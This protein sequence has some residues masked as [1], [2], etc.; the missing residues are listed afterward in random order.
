MNGERPSRVNIDPKLLCPPGNLEGKTGHHF[1]I[2]PPNGE[3]SNGAC[4]KCGDVRQYRNYASP[5]VWDE[6]RRE[7]AG[8]GL[9]DVLKQAAILDPIHPSLI[10]G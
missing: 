2:E 10:D 5:V 9:S 6:Y 3:I 8:N 7:A 1:I 4:K